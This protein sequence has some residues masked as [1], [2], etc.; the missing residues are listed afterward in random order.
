MTVRNWE[1]FCN[2]FKNDLFLYLLILI[3]KIEI[4]ELINTTKY[5]AMKPQVFLKCMYVCM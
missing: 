2:W 3:A 4:N 1:A 5:N